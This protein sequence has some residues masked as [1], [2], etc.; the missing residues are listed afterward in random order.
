[1]VHRNNKRKKAANIIAVSVLVLAAYFL[2]KNYVQLL[3]IQ[4]D[5][6]SPT[7]RNMQIVLLD[8]Y[9]DNYT[10]N[11]VIAFYCEDLS[12]VL[13]KRI[14]AVP[15]DTVQIIDNTLYV[16]S[17]RSSY[18]ADACF[19]YAGIAVDAITLADAQYFV[20]GDNIEESK[21]SRYKEVGIVCKKF[22]IGKIFTIFASDDIK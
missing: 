6:M 7:Y 14:A 2:S 19:S 11:D 13:V 12:T 1:M 22:I 10:S 16:N 20:I 4:G 3:L 9:S 5:S 15:G 18:Y 17:Q 21:D 8:K